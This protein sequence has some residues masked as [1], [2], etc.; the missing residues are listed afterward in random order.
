MSDAISDTTGDTDPNEAEQIVRTD[1]P[2]VAE[3]RRGRRLSLMWLV[4][5]L[6]LV[7]V[8][9]FVWREASRARGPI[10]SIVFSEAQGLDPGAEIRYRGVTVGVVR[11]VGLADDLGGVEVTAEITP[12][13]AG[14]AAEGTRFWIVRPEVSLSGVSGLETILGPR[15]IGVLPSD[16]SRERADGAARTPTLS[17]VGLDDPPVVGSG[18]GTGDAGLSLVLEASRASGIGVGA[19]VLFRDLPVGVVRTVGLRE[20][21]AAVE[22]GIAIDPDYAILVRDN[23]RFWIASGVGVD[24]GLFSGL[25]VRADSI[26]WLIRGAVAFATPDRAGDRVGAW[27]RFDLEAEPESKWLEWDPEIPLRGDTD[28]IGKD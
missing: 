16:G 4:P 23:S 20:D 19:P 10:I 6:A 9:W 17:F 8:G 25:S 13:S 18:L 28:G 24:W 11:T 14:L 3:V 22:I 7:G 5:V 1:A 2:P 12:S 27:H 21:S 15:Y 26:D